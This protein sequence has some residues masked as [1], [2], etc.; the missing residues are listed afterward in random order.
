M[1]CAPPLGLA[2]LALLSLVA[3]SPL[4]GT[5]IVYMR[6]IPICVVL[7]ALCW[8][9]W[10]LMMRRKRA[11]QPFTSSVS[12]KLLSY[13]ADPSTTTTTTTTASSTDSPTSTA[14]GCSAFVEP[15]SCWAQE[16]CHWIDESY[17]CAENSCEDRYSRER[18]LSGRDCG[19]V[20]VET[21]NGY[22]ESACYNGLCLCL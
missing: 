3:A 13:H 12:V 4:P 6:T 11:C 16:A 17:F 18:C 15:E 20:F 9:I 8:P 22:T 5:L 19:Y 2:L 21:S 14:P 1:R 10:E 7:A